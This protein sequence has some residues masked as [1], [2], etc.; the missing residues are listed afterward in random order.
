MRRCIRLTGSL[1]ESL[2]SAATPITDRDTLRTE[3]GDAE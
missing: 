2:R 3:A 1:R